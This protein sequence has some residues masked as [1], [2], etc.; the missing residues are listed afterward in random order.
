M[1][2]AELINE[3]YEKQK[4]E[5]PRE[6]IGASIIGNDCEALIAFSLRGF[7]ND[8]IPYRLQRIFRDGHRIENDVVFDIKKA[9]VRVMEVDPFTGKQWAF[10][11]FGG[12]AVGHAD[13]MIED[14]EGQS[15][16]LEIKSM[17]DK[18]WTEFQKKGVKFSHRNYFSQVQ[19]MLGLG[20]MDKC[21]F[22]AY[23]KNNSEY[24]SEL[25]EYDEFYYNDLCA[26]VERILNG[27][28]RKIATDPTDWR[29]RGCFKRSVCWDEKE[30]EVKTLKTCKNYQP[31]ADGKWTCE[32]GCLTECLKWE[33]Y[34]PLPKTIST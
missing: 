23:N 1:K 31:K 25:I 22:I 28:A 21:V 4:D 27:E 32:N 7:P 18:K 19:F 24:C 26:K 14:A 30:I 20:K 16:L 3:A 17:N 6:Y 12:H 10:Q 29:C 2:L 34:Q 33:R 8:P 9:K 5:K 13:G 15:M 11:G